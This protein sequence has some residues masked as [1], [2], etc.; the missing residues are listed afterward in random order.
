VDTISDIDIRN[1][2]LN[3]NIISATASHHH[4][5]EILRRGIT[6]KNQGEDGDAEAALFNPEPT[7]ETSISNECLMEEESEVEVPVNRHKKRGPRSSLYELCKKMQRPMPTFRTS[8]HKLKKKSCP[9]MLGSRLADNVN[10]SDASHLYTAANQEHVHLAWPLWSDLR[11]IPAHGEFCSL[12]RPLAIFARSCLADLIGMTTSVR[13]NSVFRSFFEKQKL[14]GPKFIDWYKQLRL[15][16]STEDKEK[17]LEQPIPTAPVAAAPDQPIPPAA[18]TTYNEWIK[19]QKEIDMKSYIDQLEH[20]GHPVTLNLGVSLILVGL[21]K[22]YDS[23]VQNYNMHNMGMT[24]NELHA[25]LK[26]HED[27][28][29]KKDDNP[30]LYAIRAGRGL[31]GSKKLKPGAL[32]L[33]VGDGHRAAV[34]AIGT[35]HLELPSGLVIVLNNCYYA[36]SIT[37]GVISVS[38][39]FDDGFINHFDENNVILV[40]KNNLVYFMAVLRDGIFEIDISCSNTNDSSMYA[41]SNK[42]AKINLDS[43]LLWHCRLGHISKKRIEKLQHDGLLNSIDFITR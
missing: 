16:L 29:P 9:K 37:R 31:R 24:I 30:A 27:M 4:N 18:L 11:V 35:Y 36:P 2:S 10:K 33:Y 20:L 21:S 19:N 1:N 25:M 12:V 26:L 7:A 28:L 14:T 23:F 6:R 17:Y 13:N 22:E 3:K 8:E 43:S 42:R 41:I 32:S 5:L 40:S 34:E 38:H 15:V 39:L